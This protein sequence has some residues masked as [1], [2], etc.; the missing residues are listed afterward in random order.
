MSAKDGDRSDGLT[1]SI[2]KR[3][4]DENT[5]RDKLVEFAEAFFRAV[6]ALV[7]QLESAGLKV[8]ARRAEVEDSLRLEL[9]EEDLHDRILFMT[10]HNVAYVLEHSGAHG[11]LYAF[12]ISEGSGQAVPV[13]RFLI[14]KDGGVH[15]EGIV[16]PLEGVDVDATARRLIEAV[17]V[18]GRTYWT[19]L[20]VMGPVPIADLEMPRLKGQIGFRPRSVLLPPTGVRSSR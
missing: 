19:P 5:V 15:C 1:K 6:E 9:E 16:A 11:A 13:E 7:P 3:V 8:T 17:W 2:A 14:S 12:V 10:Q 4:D 18:Q 20:E